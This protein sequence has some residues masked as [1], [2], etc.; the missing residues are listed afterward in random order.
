MPAIVISILLIGCTIAIYIYLIRNKYSNISYD[1]SFY[2]QVRFFKVYKDVN[3]S[4]Y[5]IKKDGTEENIFCGTWSDAD[6]FYSSI[7]KKFNL[8]KKKN[9]VSETELEGS[10]SF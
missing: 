10:V 8:W 7:N 9:K 5:V 6:D 1:N 3:G 4:V 2:E